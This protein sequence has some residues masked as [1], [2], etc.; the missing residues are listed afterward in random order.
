MRRHGAVLI[1]ILVCLAVAGVLLV[2]LAKQAAAGRRAMENQQWNVQAQW[3]AEAGVEAPWP[4]WPPMPTTEAKHG[5]SRPATW[6]A[7]T[8]GKCESGSTPS[9]VSPSDER[10][11]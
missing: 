5:A 1:V 10:F 4:G 8:A 11:T 7:A 3:L 6:A 9:P 2:L